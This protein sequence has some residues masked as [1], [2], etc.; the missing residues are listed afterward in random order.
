MG[1]HVI[2]LQ[3]NLWLYNLDS[4]ILLLDFECLSCNVA[5]D[6]WMLTK[7]VGLLTVYSALPRKKR[8]KRLQIKQAACIEECCNP[9]V[10][11][12]GSCW[13]SIECLLPACPDWRNIQAM[14]TERRSKWMEMEIIA[15]GGQAKICGRH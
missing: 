11:F 14:A 2:Y 3:P 9:A 4:E 6:K 15:P 13:C 10:S 7:L 5:T 12:T 1:S 8:E